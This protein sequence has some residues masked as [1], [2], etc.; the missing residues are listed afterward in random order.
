MGIKHYLQISAFSILAVISLSSCKDDSGNRRDNDDSNG[1]YTENTGSSVYVENPN[2]TIT[3][4]GREVDVS[5]DGVYVVDPIYVESSDD[6]EYFLDLIS[7]SDYESLYNSDVALYIEDSYENIFEE[8]YIESG[9]SRTSFNALDAGEGSWVALAYEIADGKLGTKY[10][11]CKFTSEAI[12]MTE[13]ESYEISYNGRTTYE[14]SEVES[15]SIKSNSEYPYYVEISYPEYITEYYSGDPTGL[16]NDSLDYLASYMSDLSE[17]AN[18]IYQGNMNILFDKLR[19]GDW[20]VY[21]FGVDYLGN[22]TGNWSKLDFNIEEEEASE[23]FNQWLGTWTIGGTPTDGGSDIYYNINI[24]S[25]ENNQYYS[26]ENWEN[27]D[28]YVFETRFNED[29]GSMTFTSQYLGYDTYD[30]YI[31]DDNSDGSCDVA[32]IGN[33]II[34]DNTY[35]VDYIDGDYDIATA[36]FTEA[37]I[38]ADVTGENILV[39]LDNSQ[40]DVEFTSMQFVDWTFDNYVYTYSD[41]VPALP[42]TMTKI[43]GDDGSVAN[44]S[45]L[46]RKVPARRTVVSQTSD[47]ESSTAL[48][49]A[50]CI[51]RTASG[52][53]S[54]LRKT[55]TQSSQTKSAHKGANAGRR[56]SA[57]SATKAAANAARPAQKA[58]ATQRQQ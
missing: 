36:Q 47:S 33:I 34:G 58:Q 56:S 26:I 41:A 21:A 55:A 4:R 2:W 57:D 1:S 6:V 17:F 31:T 28:G 51:R 5:E 45:S 40:Y 22:L 3:Y 53:S 25:A 19:H 43:S 44:V 37:G 9:D 39:Q 18:E 12:T 11:L 7:L 15:I 10:S 49:E 48:T 50:S 14:G 35:C 24:T 23:A 27:I 16:F 13:D 30:G 8:K 54:S 42:M 29:D 52:Q 20:T 38:E 32:F 46:S